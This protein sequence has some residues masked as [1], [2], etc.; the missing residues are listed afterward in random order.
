MSGYVKPSSVPGSATSVG[1]P[2]KLF[3]QARNCIGDIF[4]TIHSYIGESN[5]I[6]TDAFDLEKKLVAPERLE[7]LGKYVEKTSGVMEILRRDRMKVVFFGRTSNGKSTVINA[8][9]K[10]KILPSGLGHTTSCF[11][12]V[13]GTESNEAYI[14]ID[15][16]QSQRL[17]VQS[18][19][20]MASALSKV[21]LEPDSLVRICWP[22]AK[23][24]LL[25]EDV[26]F[27]DS[28]GIDMSP[29]MDKWID[30][31]CLD[32]DVFVLVVNAE[33]TLMQTEKNFFHKVSTRLSKPNIFI[34]NNRW[35]SS[36]SEPETVEEVRQQHL[37]RDVEFLT[38]E[39]RV[40]DS[41]EAEDRIFFI[42]ALETLRSCGGDSRTNTPVMPTLEGFQAR[43]FEF[44]NF[45]K[46]F[47]ECISH[48]ALETKFAH[49]AANGLA[50]ASDVKA[51][52]DEALQSSTDKRLELQKLYDEMKAQ[53]EY[54]E[55]QLATT[56]QELRVSVQEATHQLRDKMAAVLT[57]EIRRIRSIL[58]EFD[59]PFDP[60]PEA[61]TIYK[62]ELNYHLEEC[63]SRNLHVRCSAFTQQLMTTTVQHMQARLFALMPESKRPTT[64]Q[65]LVRSRDFDMSYHLDCPGLCADFCEDIEFRFSLGITM[66]VRRFSR[67]T[68]G[69]RF[70]PFASQATRQRGDGDSD[71]QVGLGGGGGKLSSQRSVPQSD[72]LLSCL[73]AFTSAYSS[74]T[75]S[76]LAI[77]ALVGK[78]IGWRVIAVCAGAYGLVYVY[79]RLTWTS[80][81]Q[82]ETFH[83]QYVEHIT[84]RL[85]M[86]VE[87][88]SGNCSAQV[89]Q[90]LNSTLSQLCH[91]VTESKTDMEVTLNKHRDTSLKLE[92]LMAKA[93]AFKEKADVISVQITNFMVQYLKNPSYH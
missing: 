89:Q 17:S 34:L 81:V 65:G 4:E 27:V 43:L 63:L 72:L 91:V 3:G 45:E 35:D 70:G 64:S 76:T 71:D 59:R 9:L 33:S 22:S 26:V 87:L 55:Q 83:R 7:L 84:E 57:D 44:A 82:E 42:S 48:T 68:G 38:T 39:L 24:R 18:V 32:A 86:I 1:S 54:T 90:E 51:V 46:K 75:I 69:A 8:M 60:D 73:G 19:S 88:T 53:L 11:V 66:L 92:S 50:I 5:S 79:E 77:V 37:E 28:P 52:W 62:K 2:L 13:E 49:H 67:R 40:M 74:T 47:E 56:A 78:V 10:N 31:F 85:G 16:D 23:C 25:F 80:K 20:H 93:K 58:Q 6:I 30:K 12:Q 29:N 36:A 21:K 14:V 41:R 15:D 61:L